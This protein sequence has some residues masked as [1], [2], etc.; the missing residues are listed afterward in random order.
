MSISREFKKIIIK[1]KINKNFFQ[2]LDD[3]YK[4]KTLNNNK[5]FALLS[6]FKYLA[7]KLEKK[8]S[9]TIADKLMLKHSINSNTI[10]IE[11]ITDCNLKCFNCNRSCRQAPST[12]YMTLEQIEK[13][14][15]E[16]I[17][18]KKKWK[19]IRIL[20]GEPTLHNNIFE[21]CSLLLDY[22]KNYSS[23]TLISLASNGYGDIVNNILSKI[24]ENI[25]I[26]NASKHGI[27]QK[28][29]SFNLAPIDLEEFKN[30]AIDYSNG[31]STPEY[32]GIALTR[33]GYYACGPAA[34]ID[35]VLNLNIGIK[36]L[37]NISNIK[38]RNQLKQ[39]CQYC[40]HFKSKSRHSVCKSNNLH[41]INKEQV[42]NSWKNLYEKYNTEKPELSLF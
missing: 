13:F 6:I 9:I 8:I 38:F 28:F 40:G 42:S 3:Y 1:K 32:A 26:I 14:I 27:E 17:K 10:E 25:Y 36:K 35:R 22:K 7:L 33:Y 12:E 29:D 11:I 15:N 5:I 39:L 24:P 37:K 41:T 19:E 30:N 18:L 2:S 34:G 4:F 31:C 21:I 16:S 23:K 20:G